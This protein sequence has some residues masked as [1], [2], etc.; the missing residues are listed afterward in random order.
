MKINVIIFSELCDKSFSA[1]L[2][3]PKT[4]VSTDTGVY[5]P[6]PNKDAKERFNYVMGLFLKKAL[7]S[8]NK[9]IVIRSCKPNENWRLKHVGKKYADM[10]KSNRFTSVANANNLPLEIGVGWEKYFDDYFKNLNF[11]KIEVSET[12]TDDIIKILSI[13]EQFTVNQ[14][15]PTC[16]IDSNKL[17]DR[18]VENVPKYI[19]TAINNAYMEAMSE[20]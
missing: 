3:N 15:T 4:Y 5:V 18:S 7:S 12:D 20:K 11:R 17:I 14:H 16:L 2:S 9:N 6:P 8:A 19:M 13:T 1:M 10:V